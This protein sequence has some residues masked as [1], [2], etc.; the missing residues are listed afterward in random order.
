[1]ALVSP[2]RIIKEAIR[3]LSECGCGP[4]SDPSDFEEAVANNIEELDSLQKAL[5]RDG[6]INIKEVS[7]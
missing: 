6:I 3:L 4:L 2:Q 7:N 5:Y 1:M